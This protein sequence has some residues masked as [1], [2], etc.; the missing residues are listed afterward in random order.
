MHS[1]GGSQRE[2]CGTF[3]L[4]NQDGAA[5]AHKFQYGTD[6]IQDGGS[7]LQLLGDEKAVEFGIVVEDEE[8]HL[9]R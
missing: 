7:A 9:I 8:D 1:V 4:P 3:L 6:K 2:S 5:S